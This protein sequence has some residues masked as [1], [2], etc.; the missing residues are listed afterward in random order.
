MRP[1]KKKKLTEPQRFVLVAVLVFAA[2]SLLLHLISL[3]LDSVV[4]LPEPEAAADTAQPEPPLPE[5]PEPD[6]EPEPVYEEPAPFFGEAA[7]PQPEP[8]PEPEI[9]VLSVATD[10][11]HRLT[12]YADDLPSFDFSTAAVN[13]DGS[14][15]Y[16]ISADGSSILRL[17]A[18][19]EYTSLD[20]VRE[21]KIAEYKEFG[22]PY[23]VS[24]RATGGARAQV[25]DHLD[26]LDLHTDILVATPA[27]LLEFSISRAEDADGIVYSE[28]TSYLQRQYE[29]TVPVA[30][31]IAVPKDYAPAIY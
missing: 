29:L 7:A 26:L 31:E 24:Q 1:K 14:E 13:D 5:L 25:I 15:L 30:P 11:A 12:V 23:S 9:T 6:P 18:G 19:V 22:I 8:K 20:A 28:V 3:Q 2:I 27:G 16:V 17:S 4:P 10:E 21:S